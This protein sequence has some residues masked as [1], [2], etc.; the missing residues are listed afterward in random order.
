MFGDSPL[1]RR[2]LLRGAATV[3]G[4]TMLGVTAT[5]LPASALAAPTVHTRSQ[6]N[7]RPPKSAASVLDRAPDHI[8]VHHTASANQTDYS[9]AAA[10]ALSRS[11]QNFHMDSNGWADTGQQLTISRGGHLM[12]GRNRSLQAIQ[13]GD[14]VVGAHTASHNDHTIGIEN[15]GLYM[16]VGPTA[17]LWAKL[18]ETCAWLCDVY[19]LDPH[20]AIVGHRDYNA[21]ACPGDRLYARLPDLRN[22]VAGLLGTAQTRRT[23]TPA[24]APYPGPRHTFDHGP[25]LGPGDPTR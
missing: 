9:L 10:Y 14:H 16:T 22:Q 21:T 6:W 11:I 2:T 20:G 15:E 17:A 19:G 8:V 1:D 5:A 4:G 7:A 25:A 24:P 23:T 13:A 12:E 3:A 18:V